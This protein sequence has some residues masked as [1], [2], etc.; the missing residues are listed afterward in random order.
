MFRSFSGTCATLA[1]L[2]LLT[3][4]SPALAAREAA[5]DPLPQLGKDVSVTRLAE[6]SGTAIVQPSSGAPVAAVELWFRAPSVGFGPQPVRSLARVAA[7]TVAGSKPIVGKS[8]GD[9]VSELGGKL[10]INTYGDSVQVAALVPAAAAL[11]IVK[12]MTI[13]YFSP[14]ISND[15]FSQAVRDVA[16]EALIAGFDPTSVV[17]DDVFS[18][19]FA[20]GPDHYSSLGT[21]K[22]VAA[23]KLDDVRSFSSRAFRSQNAFL[24]VS[25]SVDPSVVSA[26]SKG[27]S[28]AP[29]DKLAGQEPPAASTLAAAPQPVTHPF[30]QAVDGYAWPGP[31]IAKEDEATALDFIS[32]YLFRPGYGTIAKQVGERYPSAF[33]SG[34]FVTLHD[35][36]VMF[37]A[38]G[39]A[40]MDKL[41][42][43][44]NDGVAAMRT[45]LDAAAFNAARNA[46]EYHL[47]SDL[48]TPTQQ[49]DN[50][51]WY[52][53]EGNPEYAPG[54]S[55][56]TGAYF[57]AASALTPASVAAVAQ[58]YLSKPGASA[59]LVPQKR[60]TGKA[61][62]A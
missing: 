57:R 16:T 40:E 18:A 58:K 12:S 55:G 34:Q 46:F 60:Q 22:D 38:F 31:P 52:S 17:R 45:P 10:A 9:Q 29:D 43:I 4:V 15:G 27:R 62:P 21:A 33:I 49:A 26:A 2:L 30:D 44:V 42:A 41:R 8:L 53:V 20:S 1:G 56:A 61:K 24:V 23:V 48:Q 3:C 25:G 11:D 19:L 50:L 36:G 28:A 5:N 47:L 37:V 54:V 39:G 6:N 32:D 7:Q 14:V 59:T 51:G 13:A 35:P